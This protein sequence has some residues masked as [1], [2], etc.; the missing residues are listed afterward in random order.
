MGKQ[1]KISLF[2]LF[3]IVSFVLSAATQV[4]ANANDIKARMQARLPEIGALKAQGLV[5]ENYKGYLEF[6]SGTTAK[7]EL[8]QAE[9]DDRRAVYTAIAG[10]QKTTVEL[11]GMRRAK[12]IAELA[13]PGTWLQDGG[14]RWY[15]K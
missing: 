5:G 7:V 10:Q 6:V 11:V 9:N 8:V 13:G 1:G 3:L 4:L 14:G 12:Q 15:K 2:Y